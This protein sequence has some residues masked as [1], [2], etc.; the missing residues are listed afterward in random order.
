MFPSYIVQIFSTSLDEIKAI[1]KNSFGYPL[2]LLIIPELYM[3]HN[4]IPNYMIANF[5]LC[6]RKFPVRLSLEVCPFLA[7]RKCFKWMDED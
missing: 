6:L 2:Y 3:Y 4:F 5:R 7:N 1:F